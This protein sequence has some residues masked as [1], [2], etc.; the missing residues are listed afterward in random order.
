MNKTTSVYRDGGNLMQGNTENK[1]Y[2]DPITYMHALKPVFHY[3]G[4]F[5]RAKPIFF[6][7]LMSSPLELIKNLFSFDN[8]MS[9]RSIS[10]RIWAF[11]FRTLLTYYYRNAEYWNITFF[12]WV[13]TR[14]F[15]HY[16]MRV[17]SMW[18][19][20]DNTKSQLRSYRGHCKGYLGWGQKLQKATAKH[21]NI[22]IKNAS[23]NWEH[24]LTGERL[25]FI[26]IFMFMSLTIVRLNLTKNWTVETKLKNL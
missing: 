1:K 9:F 11:T 16:D 2:R 3:I 14:S 17:S 4:D 21:I 7:C 18:S 19:F 23:N 12:V 22:G 25:W 20:Y 13:S 6:F 24:K 15:L 10:V 8:N 5:F 26:Y